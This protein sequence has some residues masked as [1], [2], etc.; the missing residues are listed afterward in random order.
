MTATAGSTSTS[1]K[2]ARSLPEARP[3]PA[4]DGDRLFRNRRDGTFEDVTAAAGIARIG[5]GYAFGVAAGDYDSDGRPDLFITR[6]GSYVLLHNQGDGTFEDATERPAW[7]VIATGRPRRR[8]PI[9]TATATSTCMSATT[10]PGTPSIPR[11]AS[12]PEAP[13]A[14]LLPAARLPR[15]ARSP[16]PQRRRSFR[17]RHRVGRDRRSRRPRPGRGGRRPR[18]RRADRPVRGQRHDGQSTCSATSGA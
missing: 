8:S 11:S 18:R 2:A 9:S 3:I 16:V 7:A 6:F 17:R 12:D 10:W 13:A 5:R 4:R 1:F 15:A 14:S